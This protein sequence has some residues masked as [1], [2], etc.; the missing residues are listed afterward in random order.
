[1]AVFPQTGYA[2]VDGLNIGYQV[3]GTGPPDLVCV[4]G[5][6]T[7]LDVMWEDLGFRH[8]VT[9]LSAFSRLILFDKRGVGLSDRLPPGEMP[10]MEQRVDDLRAVMDAV[11]SSSAYLLAVHEAG[12]MCLLFAATHPELVAGLVLYGTW[13]AGTRRTEYP[14]APTTEEHDRLQRAIAERWGTGIGISNYAPSLLDDE[15][16]RRWQGRVE[17]AG[18]TPATARALAEAMAATD[19]RHVLPT[20][21]V[22]TLV[23]HRVSDRVVDQG[24]ARYLADHIFGA[25]LVLLP[26]G[27]HWIGVDPD[28]IVDIVEEFVSGAR[29]APLAERILATIMFTDI[30]GSTALGGRL[31]DHRMRQLLDRHDEIAAELVLRYRGRIINTTGD[32][33]LAL[34]DGPA[35]AVRCALE[36]IEKLRTYLQLT[37]RV[38]LHVGEVEARGTNVTGLAVNLAARIADLANGGEVLV[39][40]TIVDLVAGAGLEFDDRGVHLLKGLPEHHRLFSVR[41]REERS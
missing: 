26:S 37:V 30:V 6:L 3:F 11:G 16:F 31:G 29:P 9:R 19:V 33:L 24:N 41:R 28:Q 2:R 23:V 25:R 34:F 4:A 5:W 32:G 12:P 10:P 27:D 18:A 8:F 13:A 15:S 7:H 17:R 36:L 22:P 39:S 38:G 1:V 40:R 35:R 20:V 21:Q 14:W